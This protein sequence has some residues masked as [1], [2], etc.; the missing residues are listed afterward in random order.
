MK[1]KQKP[2]E[3]VTDSKK[4]VQDGLMPESKH[5]LKEWLVHLKRNHLKEINCQIWD[6]LSIRTKW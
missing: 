2:I 4:K 5:L 6:S 1:S 3:E